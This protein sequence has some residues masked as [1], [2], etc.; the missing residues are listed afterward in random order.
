MNDTILRIFREAR[1]QGYL[2]VP[3]SYMYYDGDK[4]EYITFQQ[5]D[6]D[7]V[8]SADNAIINYVD[9]YDFDIYSKSNYFETSTKIIE[10]LTTNGFVWQPTRCS[11]DLYEPDTGYYHKTLCFAIERS[12]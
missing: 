8:L 10:L 6:I 11:G 5:T 12:L 2:N 7:N 1:Q 3:I 4:T 9:Y